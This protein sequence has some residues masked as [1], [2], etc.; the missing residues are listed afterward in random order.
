[1]PELKI[2]DGQV[3]VRD[4]VPEKG[5]KTD[6]SG[7]QASLRGFALPQTEPAQAEVAFSTAL[8]EQVKYAGS[9]TLSPLASE[10]AIEADRIRLVNYQPYYQDYI[11]Y[12]FE[13]GI[14]D[15]LTHYSFSAT[16]QG[17]D[18]KLS[19]F[20]L[21]L[22][23]LRLRKPGETEDFLRAKT[24]Q[25]RD[26]SVDVRKLALSVGQ[27]S[28]RDGFL[29]I[30]REQDGAINATRIL[31]APKEAATTGR[32]GTP[33]LVTLNRADA[34]KWKIAFTDLTP[35][36]PVQHRR[37][38][39]HAQ[40]QR[41]IQ[42]EGPPRAHRPH[43]KV[44]RDRH[45]GGERSYRDQPGERRS[46]D[47]LEGFRPGAAAALLRRPGQHPDHQRGSFRHRCNPT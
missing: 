11:L 21:A 47:R 3:H 38:R 9:L 25:I 17:P 31:P 45:A 46:E 14:A 40:G 30:I 33:W 32:Q 29:N 20:N 8:G 16:D 28:T 6:L 5:F 2:S 27:F 36:Q 35:P 10:G 39:R 19:A 37:R 24:A 34:Q 4:L 7:I 12:K 26:A 23:S 1:M 13:D 18:V 41:H 43:G 44:E 22:A 42:P 15:L